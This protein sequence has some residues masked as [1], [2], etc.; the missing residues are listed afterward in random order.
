LIAVL[1]ARALAR[2]LDGSRAFAV[3]PPREDLGRLIRLPFP[4]LD[5][6]LLLLATTCIAA[7]A[8][9][10]RDLG[11]HAPVGGALITAGIEALAVVGCFL[12]LGPVLGQRRR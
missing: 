5:T 3:R 8:A 2:R 6:R 1:R 10:A 12:V 7:A 11:E 4:T 9:F